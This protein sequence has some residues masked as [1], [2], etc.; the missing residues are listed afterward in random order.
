LSKSESLNTAATQSTMGGGA[1]GPPAYMA[2]EL[3]DSN[4]F[5]EKT[6]V[7]AYALIIFEVLTGDVPWAGINQMQIMM[8]VCIK[9][10]R[11]PVS[12]SAPSDLVALMQRS[13][14]HEPDARPTFAKVK[15]E[16]RGGPGTPAR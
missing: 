12:E 1:R 14:A 3:L 2:P 11:P 4:T 9:K 16:L 6:D 10:E 7:Y 5:T 15:A 8:Q 13:W